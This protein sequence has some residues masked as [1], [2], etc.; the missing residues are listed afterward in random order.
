MGAILR[1]LWKVFCAIVGGLILGVGVGF[2]SS[3]LW[4]GLAAAVPGLIAGWIFGKHVS[5]LDAFFPPLDGIL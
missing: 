4:L 5:P 1:T 3:S 2:W